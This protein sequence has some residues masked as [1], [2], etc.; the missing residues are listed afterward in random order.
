MAAAD[1]EHL[2]LE[3]V[4]KGFIRRRGGVRHGEILYTHYSQA[5]LNVFKTGP[6]ACVAELFN[7]CLRRRHRAPQGLY[8]GPNV[9]Q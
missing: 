6:P 2:Q 4:P 1:R 3:E 5:V 9:Y 7:A 8:S